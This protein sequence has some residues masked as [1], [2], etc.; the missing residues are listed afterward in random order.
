MR[1][2]EAEALL[3]QAE[4][5]LRGEVD[6]AAGVVLYQARGM[7]ELARVYDGRAL[8]AFRSAE[9]L[10]GLL[11]AKHSRSTPMRSH[12]LQ[13]LISLGDAES[14]EQALAGLDDTDRGELR[15]ALAALRLAYG[16]PVSAGHALEQALDL[17]EP[18]GAVF[19]FVLH[20]APELLQRH[21]RRGTSRAAPDR[22]DPQPARPPRG[23]GVWG[24]G[25][26]P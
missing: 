4:R 7:L 23:P 18:D 17:V 10:V 11:V 1:L 8:A 16:D 9:R 21:G 2:E 26:P 14:G 25:S 15:N 22:G 6:P 20:L 12:M 24:A 13:T 19:A 5:T 3:D